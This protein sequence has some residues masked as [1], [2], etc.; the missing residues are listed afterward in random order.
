MLSLGTLLLRWR[1]K[2]ILE[3]GLALGALRFALAATG[4]RW[5]LVGGVFLHGASF[6]L[7]IITAQIYLD[8]RVDPAWRARGQA[9]MALMNSGVGSMVGYLG[10][11]AWFAACTKGGETRW[12]IFWS[13]LS[14][15]MAAVLVFFL[16]MY[17]G[18]GRREG[19]VAAPAGA[20]AGWSGR[21]R[22]GGAG[23]L[24]RAV[25]GQNAGSVVGDAEWTEAA[26]AVVER[27]D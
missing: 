13:L 27:A 21:N 25:E 8:Q 4:T 20:G 10:T 12:P 1:L 2:W 18:R 14:A 5:G 23:Q 19:R 9:L 6:T 15:A 3:L 7:V 26:N 24:G 17:R 22:S 16:A 11:G